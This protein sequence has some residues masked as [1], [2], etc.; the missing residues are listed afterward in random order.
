[1]LAYYTTLVKKE[2][3]LDRLKLDADELAVVAN[4]LVCEIKVAAN[5]C[6]DKNNLC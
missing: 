6:K 2:S 4:D 3:L 5:S 1:M